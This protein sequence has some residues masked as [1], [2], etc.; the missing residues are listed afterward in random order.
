MGTLAQLENAIDLKE[1]NYCNVAEGN[2]LRDFDLVTDGNSA[3]DIRNGQEYTLV[4][5]NVFTGIGMDNS[6][7]SA[8]VQVYGDNTSVE[9]F[10]NLMFN[11]AVNDEGLFALRL[12]GTSHTG[13]GVFHNTI[14]NIENG[15]LLEDYGSDPDFFIRNNI[16]FISDTYFENWGTGG[17]F[18][19]SY[20]LYQT[21]PTPES[22]MPYYGSTGRQVGDPVFADTAAED[23]RLTVLSTLAINRSASLTNGLKYDR[24]GNKRYLEA[25]D[26]GAFEIEGKIVWTGDI[27]SDWHTSGNWSFNSI[28]DSNSTVVIPPASNE[29]VLGGSGT[30]VG[31]VIVLEG[32]GLT[33]NAVLEAVG[34]KPSRLHD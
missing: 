14:Y 9:V 25:P 29:P 21:D 19:V 11:S 12:D 3:V 24:E 1:N 22:Y 23:F 34:R 18:E 10:N 6:G 28:P 33:I 17:R 8:L 4:Y 20:N 13:S 32:A 31:A 26:I 7:T 16:V 27:D 30:D 5:G 15:F 2:T